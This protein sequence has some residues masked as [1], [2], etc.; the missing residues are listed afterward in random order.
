[1]DRI[2]QITDPDGNQRWFSTTKVP[3]VGEDG[4]VSGIVGIS[5]DIT[6][7]YEV[8]RLKNEFIAI[9]SHELRTPLTS[10]QGALGLIAA[11]AL[12]PISADM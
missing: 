5:R 10:I 9:V 2:E 7:R 8:E 6:V 3:I 11:G 1:M 12:G 4:R